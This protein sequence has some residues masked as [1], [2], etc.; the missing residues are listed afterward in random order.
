MR[1]SH[2]KQREM[3][4]GRQ[5]THRQDENGVMRQIVSPEKLKQILDDDG[6]SYSRP[7]DWTDEDEWNVAGQ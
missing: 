3:E 2:T 1:R 5:V 7:D 4:M 6:D